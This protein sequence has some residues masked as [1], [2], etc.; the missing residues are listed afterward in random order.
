[1]Q[2]EN[3]RFLFSLFQNNLIIFAFSPFL[4]KYNTKCVQ[5]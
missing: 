4:L 3:E 5:N 2:I 1:M